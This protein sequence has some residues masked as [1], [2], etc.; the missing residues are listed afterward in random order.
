MKGGCRTA[1]RAEHTDNNKLKDTVDAYGPARCGV[2]FSSRDVDAIVRKKE[3]I[4]ENGLMKGG[5]RPIRK[6]LSF[7]RNI[8]IDRQ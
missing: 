6:L 2:V 1:D 4:G 5:E 3:A 7:R 8:P